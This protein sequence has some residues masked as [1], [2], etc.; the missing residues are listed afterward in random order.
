MERRS[1]EVAEV[2]GGR[3]GIVEVGRFLQFDD[4][5]VDNHLEVDKQAGDRFVPTKVSPL[6]PL[7]L[8]LSLL[9]TGTFRGDESLRL[10]IFLP[11]LSWR[12]SNNSP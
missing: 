12:P 4:R 5:P 7:S 9:I 8:S 11:L 6:R 3:S 1:L 10:C 2:V